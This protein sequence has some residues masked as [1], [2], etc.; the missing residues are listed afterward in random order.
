MF[1]FLSSS[2]LAPAD[3]ARLRR[4]EGKLDLVLK[5]LGLEYVD[6]M[7]ANLLP[8]VCKLADEGKKIEAIKIHRQFTGASLADAKST[9]EAYMNRG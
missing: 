8:E 7:F 4:I 1:S 5:H 9:V 2:N 6:T 3:A